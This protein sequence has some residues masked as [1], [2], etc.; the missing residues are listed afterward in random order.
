[1]QAAN[2]LI[3][4]KYSQSPEAE[5]YRA[6]RTNI[7]FTNLD[8]DIR[9][10]LIT[11]ATQGEGKSTT[12]ANLAIAMVQGGKKVLIIDCDLRRPTQH[13]LF[14]I[15]NEEGI[16]TYFTDNAGPKSLIKTTQVPGL[17]IL[18]TGPIPP[19]PSEL[20][21]FRKMRALMESV[22]HVY[23][24]VLLDSPP[25]LPVTD[26]AILSTQVD[27][28]LLVINSG[29]VEKNL[30]KLA[31]ERLNNVQARIIGTV[32]N[33]VTPDKGYYHYYY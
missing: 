1:V 18:P 33:R 2:N 7:Q 19:N 22:V 4:L 25:L 20:V 24:I 3:T 16:T 13:K 8:K 11:S 31:V 5:A 17:D 21:G 30:A 26:A 23:D 27:G 6:L 32:L 29:M 10:L 9:K 12:L 14:W 28:V 15:P